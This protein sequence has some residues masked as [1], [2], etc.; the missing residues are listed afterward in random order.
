MNFLAN[1]Q[2]QEKFV[3]NNIAVSKAGTNQKES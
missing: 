2:R 1:N 3:N